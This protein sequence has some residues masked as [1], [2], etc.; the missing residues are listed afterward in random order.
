[1]THSLLGLHSQV[2]DLIA[3]RKTVLELLERFP[4]LKNLKLVGRFPLDQ[5]A[6][7]T[8]RYVLKEKL[9]LQPLVVSAERKNDTFI[10]F[11][12]STLEE[13]LEVLHRAK[14]TLG[15]SR[16]MIMA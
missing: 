4:E 8:V 2:D 5:T 12:L 9:D 7:M 1:M 15:Q 16:I 11:Q 3:K 6:D 13:A 14:A 10:T